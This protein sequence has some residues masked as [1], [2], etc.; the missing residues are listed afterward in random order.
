MNYY[1]GIDLGGTNI[2]AA[3][4]D[5]RYA[6]VAQDSRKTLCP[7]A[8]EE[9][10]DDMVATALSALE[11]AGLSLTDVAYVGVG[12]PGTVNHT[13]RVIE[14]SNNLDFH[15]V[16]MGE[17]LEKKFLK[18]VLIENDANAAAYGEYWVGSGRELSSMVLY[19]LGTGVGGGIVIGDVVVEGHHSTG[20]ECGHIII[21]ISP[22]ARLCPCG[23][24]GHLEAY[25]SATAVLKRT[26]EALAEGRPTSL[27]KRMAEG[28]ALTT[29]LLAE[30]AAAGD[31][32]AEAI[33]VETAHY[34]GV[35]V[36][37][38]M[39]AIDPQGVVIGGAMT[40]GG[41]ETAVGRKFLAEVRAEVGR[42]A[43]PVLAART[44]IEYA[45]LGGDAGFIGAAGLARLE[46]RRRHR[47]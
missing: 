20:A 4:L 10:M 5:E 7:R 3:V 27:R 35:G 38:L 9:I 24:P 15:Q 44:S 22:K 18:P 6:I 43:F 8:A 14:Y 33:I 26:E 19:T 29:V 31:P 45:R 28:S 2:A 12:C 41:N 36:T 47:M 30:E 40:F 46:H 39:H 25:C 17:Y 13:T 34:F 37:S 1:L 32:L 11:K 21:D 16:P 42:R 23:Q